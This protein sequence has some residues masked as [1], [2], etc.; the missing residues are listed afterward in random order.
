MCLK[1]NNTYKEKIIFPT[2]CSVFHVRTRKQGH[3]Q[4]KWTLKRIHLMFL[5]I[6]NYDSKMITW[7]QSSPSANPCQ[8]SRKDIWIWKTSRLNC[9]TK[10]Q[11]FRQ[12]DQGNVVFKIFLHERKLSRPNYHHSFNLPLLNVGFIRRSTTNVVKSGKN[13]NVVRRRFKIVDRFDAMSSRQNE[14]SVQN[15]SSAHAL[16]GNENENLVR[17]RMTLC[18]VPPDDSTLTDVETTFCA[19]SEIQKLKSY[20]I[21]FCLERPNTQIFKKSLFNKLKKYILLS[22]N[23][24][25]VYI[26][27]K[28][29]F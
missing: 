9:P 12:F 17:N 5:K 28:T 27:I 6:I 26:L 18:D 8:L 29:F 22:W 3:R 13:E 2:S 4:I 14:L 23:M 20:K 24:K 21:F 15:R 7:S 10:C 25:Y 11:W 16:T 19:T 1:Y